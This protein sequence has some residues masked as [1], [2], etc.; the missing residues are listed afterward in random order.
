M[1][2]KSKPLLNIKEGNIQ[3]S[4]W[5]NEHEGNKFLSYKAEKQYVQ[6]DKEGKDEWKTTNN[7]GKTDLL[8]LKLAIDKAL[9]YERKKE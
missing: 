3:V 2:E 6:K 8:Y 1:S 7:Y 5:E 9:A 4:I